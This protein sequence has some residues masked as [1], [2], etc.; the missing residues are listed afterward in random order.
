MRLPGIG[1]VTA[2]NIIAYRTEH[3]PFRAKEDLKNVTRIGEKTFDRLKDLI[4]ID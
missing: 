4:T 2:G 1:E 3:G